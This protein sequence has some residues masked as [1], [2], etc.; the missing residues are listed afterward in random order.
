MDFDRIALELLV[1]GIFQSA[2]GVM[3]SPGGYSPELS[4]TVGRPVL[5]PPSRPG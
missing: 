1:V 4:F 5:P 3:D 2:V